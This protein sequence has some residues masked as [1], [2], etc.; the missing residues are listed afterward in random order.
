MG[1]VVRLG[2]WHS[3]SREEKLMFLPYS[4]VAKVSKLDFGKYYYNV[5]WLPEEF[6]DKLPLE[7]H[8]RLR[9]VSE[10]RRGESVVGHKGAFVPSNG[11]WYLLLSKKVLGRLNA[12]LGS[13]LEVHFDLDD[14]NAVDIPDAL[15]TAL[16]EEADLQEAWDALT[17]GKQRGFAYRIAQA[18]T[19]PTQLKRLDE[20]RTELLG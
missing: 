7:E 3:D 4:F 8:P 13:K 1:M 18:K 9:V 20:L 16:E 5:L 11:Q 2:G 12:D 15:A 10:I 14:Q 17:P 19:E 6:V